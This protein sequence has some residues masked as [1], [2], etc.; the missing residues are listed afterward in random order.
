MIKRDGICPTPNG[1]VRWD[2]IFIDS[3]GEPVDEKIA[4]YFVFHEYDKKGEMIAEIFGFCKN[5]LKS[6]NSKS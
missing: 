1:G 6:Y 2:C 3:H 4:P 5:N